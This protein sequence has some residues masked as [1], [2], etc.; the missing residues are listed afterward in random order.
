MLSEMVRLTFPQKPAVSLP[1]TV[2]LA[3]VTQPSGVRVK[4]LAGAVP[5]FLMDTVEV[6]AFPGVM[7]VE[8]FN[9]LIV[10]QVPAFAVVTVP[11]ADE[12]QVTAPCVSVMR[13]V[14]E[15][16]L[17]ALLLMLA[18]KAESAGVIAKAPKATAASPTNATGMSLRRRRGLIR[19]CD[20]FS[21]KPFFPFPRKMFVVDFT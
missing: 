10:E 17:F 2:P 6:T 18:V 8:P 12:R 20:I 14:P 16:T 19:F 1:L 7:V 4:E 15:A 9:L 11:A 3:E 5:L 21:L 13:R